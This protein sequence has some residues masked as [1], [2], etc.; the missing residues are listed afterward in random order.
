MICIFFYCVDENDDENQGNDDKEKVSEKAS[1][2]PD[3]H[4]QHEKHD[5]QEQ[6]DKSEDE[7]KTEEKQKQGPQKNDQGSKSSQQK[8]FCDNSKDCEEKFGFL[9]S[10]CSNGL[11]HVQKHCKNDDECSHGFQC[12]PG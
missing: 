11:C 5:K 10:K 6:H 7:E 9:G 8:Y 4:D 2:Q 1:E 3:K 12:L